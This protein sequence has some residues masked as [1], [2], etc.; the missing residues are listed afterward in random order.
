MPEKIQTLKWVRK[1]ETLFHHK[2]HSQYITAF[3]IRKHP[4]NPSFSLRRKKALYCT[5]STPTFEAATQGK[6]LKS[7]P[8]ASGSCI[9][10]SCRTIVNKETIANRH[11]SAPC[12]YSFGHS[13]GREDKNVYL[14][15]FSWNT[16]AYFLSCC[17]RAQLLINLHLS[18]NW[19]P[20]RSLKELVGT[21]LAVSFWPTPTIKPNLWLL[22][23]RSLSTH[24]V[25]HCLR[26]SPEEWT[27]ILSHLPVIA[28]EAQHSWIP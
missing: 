10:K 5:Y 7:L 13:A 28:N 4:P 17:L 27:F 23:G 24:L 16:F 22:P 12:G 8:K 26:L 21:S 9:R 2:L 1:A 20:F 18:A 11:T 14:P 3:I 6:S 25:P 19:D 15:D